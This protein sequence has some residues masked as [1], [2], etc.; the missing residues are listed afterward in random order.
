[1]ELGD[2]LRQAREL[3]KLSQT[4]VKTLTGI[5]NKSISN[6]EHNISLPDPHTLKTLADLYD[7]SMDWLIG[8]GERI[9]QNSS[10]QL[11]PISDDDFELLAKLLSLSPQKR[12]AIEILLTDHMD[13]NAPTA[14]DKTKTPAK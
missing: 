13:F 4:Q 6:Y 11:L 14:T 8:G 2:H 12:T 10:E 5:N 3:A 1:M 9:V 7:V